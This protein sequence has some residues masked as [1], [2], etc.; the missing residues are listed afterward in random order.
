MWFH[1]DGRADDW[2]LYAQE[3]VS[4]QHNRG[5]GLGRFFDRQGRLLATAA[6]EGMIRSGS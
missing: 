2:V 3:A 5:L 4:G 1:R 6:Q